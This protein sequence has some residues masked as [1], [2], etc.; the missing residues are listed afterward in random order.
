M[1]H[2]RE[3]IRKAIVTAVTG[4]TTTGANVFSGI[5]YNLADTDL[6]ALKVYA[7]GEQYNE[8]QDEMG[9]V[10]GRILSIRIEATAKATGALDDTLDDI[11]EEVEIAVTGSS[12]LSALVTGGRLESTEIEIEPGAELPVGTATMEW[13]IFYTVNSTAPSA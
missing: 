5:T 9:A 3:Q 2:K 8:G 11:C 10:E 4:L 13:A 12:A 1:A 6:P 7:A